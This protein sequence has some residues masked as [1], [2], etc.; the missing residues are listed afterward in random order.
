MS[1]AY[2]VVTTSAIGEKCINSLWVLE[3]YG[4]MARIKRP[5]KFVAGKRMTKRAL[6]QST[7]A[8]VIW[9]PGTARSIEVRWG[10]SGEIA[11]RS[12]CGVKASRGKS[13][14]ELSSGV[15]PSFSVVRSGLSVQERSCTR[16]SSTS[17]ISF[18]T[19][20]AI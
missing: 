2:L 19:S 11:A 1:R 6:S 14:R 8:P 17:I 13:A 15:V 5:L 20:E 4:R 12:V 7:I 9:M 16:P 18:T 10:A 3:H